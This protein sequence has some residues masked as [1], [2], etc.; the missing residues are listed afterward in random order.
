MLRLAVLRLQVG[1]S[2]QCRVCVHAHREVP[3]DAVDH[4]R[5]VCERC[6]IPLGLRT[7]ITHRRHIVDELRTQGRGVGEHLLLA[8]ARVGVCEHLLL[9]CLDK[10]QHVTTLFPSGVREPR[11]VAPRLLLCVR[12]LLHSL[13][14]LLVI[15]GLIALGVLPIRS[16][17]LLCDGVLLQLGAD[18]VGSQRI[19]VVDGHLQLKSQLVPVRLQL[20][21]L[22][23][24]LGDFVARF[25]DRLVGV[26]D[27]LIRRLRVF[28]RVLEV[29]LDRLERLRRL[30]QR[31]GE[32]PPEIEGRVRHG[33]QFADVV[34]EGLYLLRRFFD[35]LAGLLRTV[36]EL[37]RPVPSFLGVL[38]GVPGTPREALVEGLTQVLDGRQSGRGGLP[39]AL[40]RSRGRL[41]KVLPSGDASCD[42]ADHVA[43]LLGEDS[44]LRNL[45]RRL[46]RLVGHGVQA[47]LDHLQDLHGSDA[48]AAQ[49]L[50]NLL[51]VGVHH[52]GVPA[53]SLSGLAHNS[54][55]SLQ[56]G[57]ASFRELVEVH[58]VLVQALAQVGYGIFEVDERLVPRQCGVNDLLELLGGLVGL[59]AHV[60]HLV[61]GVGRVA[62]QA[63]HGLCSQIGLVAHTV[64]SLVCVVVDLLQRVEDLLAVEPGDLA[65]GY[66][67]LDLVL[68]RVYVLAGLLGAALNIVG[69][70]TEPVL[71]VE[72][73]EFLLRVRHLRIALRN[74]LR[75]LL[76]GETHLA[77]CGQLLVAELLEARVAGN[78]LGHLLQRVLAD[79]IGLLRYLVG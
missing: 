63:L 54:I 26:A 1:E 74:Q 16:I 53:G 52:L 19:A 57:P 15:A 12:E 59:L 38:G 55:E 34:G 36:P 4:L 31:L 9:V 29:R 39:E 40:Q 68:E 64:E 78:L 42:H 13:V 8:G 67:L 48:V 24:Q 20:R 58:A 61:R 5:Q 72:L 70:R 33:G 30:V 73:G 17:L 32:L 49:Q 51:D 56:V 7:G 21:Q 23:V 50:H 3:R 10:G 77:Q 14:Q 47:L 69:Y 60:V 37:P 45:V 44:G 25:L 18:V 46:R 65:G 66:H 79:R 75:V 28:R 43:C 41:R 27:L 71:T 2:P 6:C 76:H 22:G 11:Q 35:L 62:L